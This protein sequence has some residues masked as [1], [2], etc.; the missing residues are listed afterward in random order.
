MAKMFAGIRSRSPNL[1]VLGQPTPTIVSCSSESLPSEVVPLDSVS[2]LFTPALRSCGMLMGRIYY[3]NLKNKETY[4]KKM[5]FSKILE[6]RVS[7]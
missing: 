1:T 6:D 7:D 2:L 3:S 4:R 5:P